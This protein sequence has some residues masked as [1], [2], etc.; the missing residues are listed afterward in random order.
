MKS[1]LNL[2]RNSPV[3]YSF[4]QDQETLQVYDSR[5]SVRVSFS[6]NSKQLKRRDYKSNDFKSLLGREV[7]YLLFPPC[8][9]SYYSYHN[10]QY[11]R[12]RRHTVITG[13]FSF[14][15]HT[16]HSFWF[17]VALGANDSQLGIW[18][19]PCYFSNFIQKYEM[20]QI[21][22]VQCLHALRINEKHSKFPRIQLDEKTGKYLPEMFTKCM[23]TNSRPL[24][25]HDATPCQKFDW[26]ILSYISSRCLT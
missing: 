25:V 6:N 24:I 17:S 12:Y 8:T 21:D 20:C 26:K 3:F 5:A 10:Y 9:E 11:R 7:K 22:I 16:S 23:W 18:E 19:G 2:H 1:P 14:D 4:Q 15:I 13:T